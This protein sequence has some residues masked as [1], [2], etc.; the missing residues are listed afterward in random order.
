MLFL[1]SADSKLSRVF[2]TAQWTLPLPSSSGYPVGELDD[3]EM[4]MVTCDKKEV[5][6]ALE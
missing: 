4:E 3:E 5:L 2:F 1:C 6:M